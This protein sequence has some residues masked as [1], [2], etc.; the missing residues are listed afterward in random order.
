[1]KNATAKLCCDNII[2]K[3]LSVNKTYVNIFEEYEM[4]NLN[5]MV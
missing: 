1:M 5:N 3:V 2:R 4:Y